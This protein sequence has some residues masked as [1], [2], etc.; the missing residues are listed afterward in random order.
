L[1]KCFAGV[2][3][4]SLDRAAR[5]HLPRRYRGDAAGI[6]A[7]ERDGGTSSTTSAITEARRLIRI[8][9]LLGKLP[10]PRTFEE[11]ADILRR[12]G[13]P[14][15]PNLGPAD[16]LRQS[17]RTG[18]GSATGCSPPMTRSSRGFW[19]G[20]NLERPLPPL[21]AQFD[22]LA[23]VPLM[24]IRGGNSDILSRET[25]EAIRARR[26]DL[27]IIEIPM[28]RCWR[29]RT[30][31]AASPGLLCCANDALVNRSVVKRSADPTELL[32]K[33]RA[34]GHGFDR[35]AVNCG[36]RHRPEMSKAS[37]GLG[38][39]RL[40]NHGSISKRRASLRSC[41]APT[42]ARPAARSPLAWRHSPAVCGGACDVS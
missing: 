14:Q 16:W 12:I 30:S 40:C 42:P 23:R 10:R 27:D 18:K 17:R 5:R 35:T 20:S 36:Q 31:S 38:L 39:H 24:V 15:F 33:Q 11:G 28:C 29:T 34:P 1:E 32:S 37:I 2:P 6:H 22:A 26:A 9:G 7:A 21:W 25:V 13:A 4:A 41:T 8:K 3:L 19:T